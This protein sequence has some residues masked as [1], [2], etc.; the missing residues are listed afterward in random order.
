MKNILQII[1]SQSKEPVN[2]FALFAIVLVSVEYAN[3]IYYALS[4]Y[5]L[6]K[7]S[8]YTVFLFLFKNLNPLIILLIWLS[9]FRFNE[10]NKSKK[11]TKEDIFDE[12]VLDAFE[13]MKKTI[14][15]Y[16]KTKHP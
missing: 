13:E 11:I 10:F 12:S 16:N 9:Q 3:D 15:Q 1:K 14:E 8:A 2:L 4:E 6:N 7:I 5:L